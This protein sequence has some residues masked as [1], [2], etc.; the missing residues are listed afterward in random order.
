MKPTAPEQKQ[1]SRTEITA[2]LFDILT[3]LEAS[4]H[5]FLLQLYREQRLDNPFEH[6]RHE[7]VMM[8]EHTIQMLT[9]REPSFYQVAD[10]VLY[11]EGY[12][13]DDLQYLE[14]YVEAVRKYSQRNSTNNRT[15]GELYGAVNKR[16][17]SHIQ[18]KADYSDTVNTEID[19]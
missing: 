15:V 11:V 5:P 14:Q 17:Q 13:K 12:L 16:E 18:P 19:T 9:G 1:L 6:V 8:L 4:W 2:A 7:A 3:I 10:P